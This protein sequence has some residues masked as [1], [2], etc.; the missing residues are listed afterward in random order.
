MYRD[1]VDSVFSCLI[2]YPM[3]KSAEITK[4]ERVFSLSAHFLSEFLRPHTH[5]PFSEKRYA[6]P[7]LISLFMRRNFRAVLCGKIHPLLE[8]NPVGSAFYIQN[9][10]PHKSQK[11]KAAP[12]TSREKEFQRGTAGAPESAKEGREGLAEGLDTFWVVEA[13]RSSR[14]TRTNLL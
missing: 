7:G 12:E 9:S 5:F 13:A 2:P 4:N 1:D 6:P 8:A 11:A 10:I 3:E 14:A